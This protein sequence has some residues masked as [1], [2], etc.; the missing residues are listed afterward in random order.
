MSLALDDFVLA[1]IRENGG[2]TLR[3]PWR[4]I[5]SD[6]YRAVWNLW[7]RDKVIITLSLKVFPRA[8][9]RTTS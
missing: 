9:E 2:M 8:A 6:I 3:K 7:R 1:H 5:T 4:F